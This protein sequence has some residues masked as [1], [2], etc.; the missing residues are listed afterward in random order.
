MF[1]PKCGNEV[2]EGSAFCAKCGAS[3]LSAQPSQAG[4]TDLITDPPKP[5]KKPPRFVIA[6]VGTVVV[7]VVLIVG[8]ATSWF[9]LAGVQPK[10]VVD[11][12]AVSQEAEPSEGT[13]DVA[14]QSDNAGE[15]S[16]VEAYTWDELSQISNEIAAAGSEDAAI[17]VAKKYNLCTSDGKLDGTQVKSVTLTDGTETY[18]QIVGFAH[19]DKTSGGKAGITFIFGDC[20]GEAPMNE[21]WTNAGG[22]EKS[23]M[24]SFLNS[25][26]LG[27]LPNELLNVVVPV[28]KLT[29]NVGETESVSSVT[30]T[31]DKLW[32]LSVTETYGDIEI[33]YF[34]SLVYG[35]ALNAEGSEYKL[36]Q[37][38]GVRQEYSADILVKCVEETAE[39]WWLRSPT[40]FGP[41][42]FC[43]VT[44]QGYFKDT[45]G[46]D[47]VLGVA[48]GFCI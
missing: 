48:P 17:E 7:I 35:D 47:G 38:M 21:E 15:K 14:Q 11:V 40:P 26:G 36:Y 6:I 19:D 25:D 4:N 41:G 22:W 39:W 43:A 20:I 8:V 37:D 30:I 3:V 33:D 10:E 12:P 44:Q 27:L 24:R 29:N 13:D 28:D 42:D 2:Q 34:G 18:V 45:A 32:L 23:Q 5:K 46:A 9:G 1:C 31:S 16:A